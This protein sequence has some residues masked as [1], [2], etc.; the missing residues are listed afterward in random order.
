ML[1]TLAFITRHPLTRERP[2]AALAR[3]AWWQVESRARQE[4]EF[5]WIEGAKLVARHGMTGATGNI[6]CGLHEFA[7]MA[8]VLH[9]L[10][11]GDP[12]VDAGANIG[13]Y[14]VLASGVC[15]AKSIAIEPDPL[16]MASLKKNIAING[17]GDRV[18]PVEAAL[19]ART[20]MALFTV[21]LDTINRMATQ[22]DQ[23]T[24]TVRVLRLD[25]VLAGEGPVLIKLDVEGFE[26]EVLAGARET[27]LQPSLLA[28]ETECGAPAVVDQLRAAGFE[29]AFYDPFTRRLCRT[30]VW[31]QHNELFVRGC[32]AVEGRLSDARPISV[33]GRRL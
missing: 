9:L 2:L 33:L 6:Y 17:I 20:G 32:D 26:A 13:S 1:Q 22:A 28:V 25:E 10:R 12:F 7:D 27:L 11:P 18:R 14:T 16:T 8:F 21:G 29:R 19:G 24:R 30:P 31:A 5:D 4:I 15:G 3:F 23:S